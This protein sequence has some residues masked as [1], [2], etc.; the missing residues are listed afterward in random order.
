[1]KKLAHVKSL[2][3]K[4]Q[5][6]FAGNQF[7]RM[8]S[9]H[10]LGQA[11]QQTQTQGVMLGLVFVLRMDN[12]QCLLLYKLTGVHSTAQTLVI[13]G[14]VR[15]LLALVW[16]ADQQKLLPCKCIIFAFFILQR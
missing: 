15:W 6:V 11:L 1:M 7:T 12:M 2:Q 3:K 13:V 8:D 5:L 14:I 10:L 16:A 4:A 9:N